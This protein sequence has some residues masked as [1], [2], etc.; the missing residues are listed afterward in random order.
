MKKLQAI[1]DEVPHSSLETDPSRGPFVNINF[2]LKKS[3]GNIVVTPLTQ[4]AT[5]A[6]RPKPTIVENSQYSFGE[7]D[8]V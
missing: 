1:I 7:I 4:L 8:A 2:R 3:A 5:K 6:V